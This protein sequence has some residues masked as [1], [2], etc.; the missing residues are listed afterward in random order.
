MLDGFVQNDAG[1]WVYE[2]DF[3]YVSVAQLALQQILQQRG[4]GETVP[5][6]PICPRDWRKEITDDALK[7]DHRDLESHQ[8][9]EG[10]MGT[11]D[12]DVRDGLRK[13]VAHVYAYFDLPLTD[14]VEVGSGPK[15]YMFNELMPPG[16]DRARW[17]QVEINPHSVASNRALHPEDRILEGDFRNLVQ[18]LGGERVA[19]IV[20]GLSSLHSMMDIEGTLASARDVLEEGGYLLHIQDSLPSPYL[21][22]DE[23]EKRGLKPPF[24][25]IIGGE[26]DLFPGLFYLEEEGTLVSTTDLIQDR[27]LRALDNIEWFDTKFHGWISV[28]NKTRDDF[29]RAFSHGHDKYLDGL[30]PKVE[31]ISAAVTLLQKKSV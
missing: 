16:L 10:H 17:A 25:A 12:D 1:V 23:L 2:D 4:G 8:H 3:P 11:R 31:I 19:K 14:G 13:L 30:E 27:I 20:T 7:S 21:A 9:E 24:K 6:T 28:I 18:V 22:F 5:F 26:E 29:S 15:G